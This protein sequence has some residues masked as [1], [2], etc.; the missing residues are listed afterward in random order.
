ME[1][2]KA[3][4]RKQRKQGA[5]VVATEEQTEARRTYVAVIRKVAEEIWKRKTPCSH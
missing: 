4:D 1:K 3:A 5:F 2:H